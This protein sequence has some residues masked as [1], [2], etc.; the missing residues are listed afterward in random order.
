MHRD[1]ISGFVTEARPNAVPTR[2]CSGVFEH[3]SMPLSCRSFQANLITRSS[4]NPD[5]AAYEA[6]R[7]CPL[8]YG[9][10]LLTRRASAAVTQHMLHVDI[11]L[12]EGSGTR[13]RKTDISGR[14]VLT[15][16]R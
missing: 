12:I 5:M 7:K 2:D 1:D 14:L 3:G 13:I 6:T 11:S 15:D 8:V 10:L 9:T 16:S 4:T